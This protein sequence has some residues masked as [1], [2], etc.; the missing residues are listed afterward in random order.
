[1]RAA[2]DALEAVS[3]ESLTESYMLLGRVPPWALRETGR[4]PFVGAAGTGFRPSP[5]AGGPP[6]R[7]LLPAET[8]ALLAGDV[9]NVSPETWVGPLSFDGA[10]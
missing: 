9:I 5:A 10:A 8:V 6:W 1:M 4:N 7:D 3:G 2:A